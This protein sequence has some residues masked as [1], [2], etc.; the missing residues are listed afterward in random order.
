M[1]LAGGLCKAR[2]TQRSVEEEEEWCYTPP[3]PSRLLHPREPPFSS[4]DFKLCRD[5]Y[6]LSADLYLLVV[7]SRH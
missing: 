4:D 1:Q 6:S 3:V 7:K 2:G 5:T